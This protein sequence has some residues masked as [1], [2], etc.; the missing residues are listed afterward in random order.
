MIFSDCV[1][2]YHMN[3]AYLTHHLVLGL[4]YLY[5]FIIINSSAVNTL[6]DSYLLR[7]VMVS[8]EHIARPIW[9]A[10]I[11]SGCPP[12]TFYI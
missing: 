6:T 11:L 12:Y 2:L 10:L 4:S 7:L 8:L 3:A 5:Y 9:K 1:A